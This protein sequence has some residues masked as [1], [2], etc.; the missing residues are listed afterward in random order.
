MRVAG[1]FIMSSKRNLLHRSSS[2]SCLSPTG[3]DIQQRDQS[4]PIE[5]LG[6]LNHF[7]QIKQLFK[8]IVKGIKN[9]VDL[10]LVHYG[11]GGAYYFKNCRGESVAF[12]KPT[13]EEPFTPNN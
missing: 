9:G 3:M 10:T 7:A 12:V 5:I 8:K 1:P 2:T 11:L 4:G 6:N 13:D